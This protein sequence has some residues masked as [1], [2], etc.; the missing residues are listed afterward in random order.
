MDG[1]KPNQNENTFCSE[2]K[3]RENRQKKIDKKEQ[4]KDIVARKAHRRDFKKKKGK[5]GEKNA[6]KSKNRRN[7]QKVTATKYRV[8]QKNILLS[9]LRKKGSHIRSG[10]QPRQEDKGKDN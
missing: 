2:T 9:R 6:N 1:T 5:K 8:R 4:E 10:I 3:N 7:I